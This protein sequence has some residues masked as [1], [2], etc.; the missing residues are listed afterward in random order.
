VNNDGRADFQLVS[1][2]RYIPNHGVGFHSFRRISRCASEIV[3][4]LYHQVEVKLL[5][6]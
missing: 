3:T 1:Q 4:A 5:M 2:N 6:L